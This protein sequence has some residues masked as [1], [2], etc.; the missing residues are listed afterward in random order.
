MTSEKKVICRK[1]GLSWFECNDRSHPA[2]PILVNEP[3]YVCSSCKEKFT[4]QEHE[5]EED[6]R[7]PKCKMPFCQMPY[8]APHG[9]A[10]K[11]EIKDL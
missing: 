5:K 4:E 3:Q 8:E 2:Q 7:C 6:D 11:I 9:I 10:E 1:C